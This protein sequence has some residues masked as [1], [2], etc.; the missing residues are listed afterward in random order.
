MTKKISNEL[1]SDLIN[2][3]DKGNLNG[4]LGTEIPTSITGE[5]GED[6]P[7]FIKTESEKII[8]RNNSY[9]ILGRDRMG[10]IIHG[11]GGLGVPNSNSIDLV[12]GIGSS[13]MNGKNKNSFLTPVDYLNKDPIHD[14]ARIYISQRSDLDS[15]FNEKRGTQYKDKKNKGVS[16]IGI[17]ADT[18]LVQA[19]RNI[20]IAA[21][22]SI[23]GEKDSHGATLP[24]PKIELIAGSDLE[25]L[26]KGNKLLTCLQK[27][28]KQITSNRAIAME[29]IK[30]IIK[31]RGELALHMHP[32][33]TG[34]ALPSPNMIASAC[35]SMPQ[36]IENLLD[37]INKEIQMAIDVTNSL[38]MPNKNFYIL[39]SRVYTS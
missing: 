32:T 14:A 2:L 13:N 31:L 24:P 37:L 7:T 18:I 3:I 30:Q 1:K 34:V 12:V 23:K 28:N 4:F 22:V 38:H 11:F 10:D 6:R 35:M 36:D 21:G 26:V 27:M 25:P 33:N 17:K 16:G 9:I 19:R 39:S 5:T 20:K 29:L 8:K 15:Y